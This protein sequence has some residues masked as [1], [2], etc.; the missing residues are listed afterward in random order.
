MLGVTL[1]AITRDQDGD[2]ALIGL[3][4]RICEG[5]LAALAIPAMLAL[6]W[7]ATASGA[8]APDT[9]STRALA[10]YLER[11][12]PGR[13]TLVVGVMRDKDIDGILQALLP[14]TGAVV[15]TQADRTIFYLSASFQVDCVV[16]IAINVRPGGSPN[17]INLN[18]DATVAAV[19]AAQL[20]EQAEVLASPFR[21]ARVRPPAL[22]PPPGWSAFP[23]LNV[24]A[25]VR[26]PDGRDGTW[27]LGMVV[28]RASFLAAA[29]CL[30][31]PYERSESSLSVEG[32]PCTLPCAARS[33]RG[34]AHDV[35][36]QRRRDDRPGRRRGQLHPLGRDRK[37]V[38]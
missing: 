21:M 6:F 28:P 35:P 38:V 15:A 34:C 37:S 1:Y 17:S 3:V 9:A 27:F 32:R 7:L 5:L 16:P 8:N 33:A 31:L 30:G 26:A 2:L 18:T 14:V 12:H 25:Y 4:C 11:W 24:R 13:P 10:A 20:L 29:R 23:E 36:A 22:P 19:E